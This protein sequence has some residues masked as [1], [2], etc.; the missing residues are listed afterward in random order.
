MVYVCA[1]GT[2][3]IIDFRALCVQYKESSRRQRCCVDEGFVGVKATLLSIALLLP[4]I[5]HIIVHH[6][7]GL[8]IEQAIVYTRSNQ[9]DVFH[10]KTM[11][12]LDMQSAKSTI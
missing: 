7:G 1:G 10:T 6:L 4:S 5:D 12:R 8:V 11:V 9:L 2:V 3:T